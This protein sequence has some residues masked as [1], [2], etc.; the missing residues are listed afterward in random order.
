MHKVL[1][2]L[3]VSLAKENTLPGEDFEGRDELGHRPL[4]CVG[5]F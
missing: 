4:G 3:V 2:P 1:E 5:P